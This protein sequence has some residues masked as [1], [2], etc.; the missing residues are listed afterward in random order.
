MPEIRFV[1]SLLVD[2]KQS[3]LY[4]AGGEEELYLWDLKQMKLNS[5]RDISI[6]RDYAQIPSPAR[7][8]GHNPSKKKK[9][10]QQQQAQAGDEPQEA[11]PT[12]SQQETESERQIRIQDEKPIVVDQIFALSESWLGVTS[13]GSVSKQ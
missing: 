11:D 9:G 7:Q 6:L 13:L 8:Q 4:S 3:M 12:T 2:E 1:S 5:K 10:K